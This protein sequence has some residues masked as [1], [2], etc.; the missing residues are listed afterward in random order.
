M[1]AFA[2]LFST[3]SGEIL[4]AEEDVPDALARWPFSIEP[5]PVMESTLYADGSVIQIE[6]QTVSRL[7]CGSDSAHVTEEDLQRM[8]LEARRA[9]ESDPVHTVISPA[10]P[11]AGLN[12]VFDTDS[13]VPAAALAALEATATYIE[14]QFSDSITVTIN[15]TYEVLPPGVIGATA[16]SFASV[17]SWSTV[18]SGLVSGMDPDDTIDALG[19][20]VRIGA[21]LRSPKLIFHGLFGYLYSPRHS[22][23]VV[24]RARS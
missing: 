1:C 18:R 7:I 22:I 15:V 13:T 21:I 9:F 17:P 2:F 8:V 16:V 3:L 6:T 10:G 24:F 14:S 23:T 11:R 20:P 5:G 4:C 19:E 12:V